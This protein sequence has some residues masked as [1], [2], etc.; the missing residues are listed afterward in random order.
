MTV[1]NSKGSQN[2]GKTTPKGQVAV[3][4]VNNAKETAEQ[5]EERL[6]QVERTH[7][8]VAQALADDAA[9]I[10]D[11][12]AKVAE[13]AAKVA[14]AANTGT[15]A[16]QPASSQSATSGTSGTN[17]H[18]PKSRRS[19]VSTEQ[20]TRYF[21]NPDLSPKDLSGKTAADVAKD[22]G[23]SVGS[24]TTRMSNFRKTIEEVNKTEGN[25]IKLPELKDGRSL[26]KGE[27]RFAEDAVTRGL[28]AMIAANR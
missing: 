16:T 25:K 9:K 17:G 15:Q 20:F 24:F 8:T 26:R 10:A 3:G 27:K 23:M 6:N 14:Q 5:K 28:K 11:A 22:L 2:K 21:L 12:G 19:K 18:S 4:M 7:A 13:A 1:K